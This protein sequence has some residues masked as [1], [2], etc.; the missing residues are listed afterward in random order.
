MTMFV[1]L[2]HLTVDPTR[3]SVRTQPFS[4]GGFI[5]SISAGHEF[6]VSVGPST[7]RHDVLDEL[8][9]LAERMLWAIRCERNALDLASN[10]PLPVE[11]RA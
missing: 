1:P 9:D 4:G 8:Q 3:M 7:S 6:K 10:T 2:P 11:Y 5:G